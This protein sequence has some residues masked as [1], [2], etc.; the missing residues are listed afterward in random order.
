MDQRNRFAT[1]AVFWLLRT[2][3]GVALAI[4][5][6]L[7]LAHLTEIRWIPAV[8]L[9]AYIDLIG[10]LPG[11]VAYRRAGHRPIGRIYYVLYNVM[12]SFVTHAVVLGVWIAV[13]GFEWAL[14]VVPI[15]LCGDRALFGNVVKSFRVPFEPEPVT[16]FVEFERRLLG[17]G[18]RG[19]R[20][21]VSSV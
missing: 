19:P 15:H 17:V 12:H 1:P 10:Y 4:C 20:H 3:Y 9:F 13:W 8:A 21:A 2:E 18:V 6:V 16:E 11:A 7:F 14:L 5:A